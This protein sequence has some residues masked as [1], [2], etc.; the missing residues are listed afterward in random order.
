[1]AKLLS[2]LAYVLIESAYPVRIGG[3]MSRADPAGDHAD[4]G[5]GAPVAG[6]AGHGTGSGATRRGYRSLLIFGV[7]FGL[8]LFSRSC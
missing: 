1:V 3:T 8:S 2:D 7:L 4:R 6:G 5:C